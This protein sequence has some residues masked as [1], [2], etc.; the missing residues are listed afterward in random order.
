M[1]TG[2][3]QR[4]AKRAEPAKTMADYAMSFDRLGLCVDTDQRQPCIPI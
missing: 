3:R 2:K 4:K 1:T